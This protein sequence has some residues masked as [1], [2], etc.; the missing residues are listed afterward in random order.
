M[1]D[2][3]DVRITRIEGASVDFDVLT[4]TAGGL[5]DVGITRSFALQLF[6]DALPR[7]NDDLPP[8][9][10]H[11]RERRAAQWEASALKAA[12]VGAG[13]IDDS[14]MQD[15]VARFL[16]ST[17]LLARHNALGEAALE[18]IEIEIEEAA[19]S[20]AERRAKRWQ[21]CH[22]FEL[23]AVATDPRWVAHLEVGLEFGTTACD[24]W[25]DDPTRPE[26]P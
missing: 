2:V 19:E 21:R 3:F 13:R 25:W 26:L 6:V 7:S 10:E 22:R 4:G 11:E 24:L 20:E 18:T 23:R 17:E 15:N 1:T 16:V 14:W 9:A 8:T 12:L 5:E